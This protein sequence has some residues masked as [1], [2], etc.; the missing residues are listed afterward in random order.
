MNN[1]SDRDVQYK[2]KNKTIWGTTPLLPP[3][4]PPRLTFFQW[5][6][7]FCTVDIL[8]QKTE[9]KTQGIRRQDEVSS[10]VREKF[11]ENILS[12]VQDV[13]KEK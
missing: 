10:I 7:G 5:F 9:P 8:Q 12:S 4:I 6:L 2:H 3:C 1:E 11:V 13:E